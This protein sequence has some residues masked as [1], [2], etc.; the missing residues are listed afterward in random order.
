M[1][2]YSIAI[3]ADR[4]Y[5][6]GKIFSNSEYLS[7]FLY[8]PD[9]CIEELTIQ[10]EQD[11]SL[12]LFNDI[13]I[14]NPVSYNIKVNRFTDELSHIQQALSD[15][16]YIAHLNDNWD[17]EGAKKVP[18][19][20]FERAINFIN[21]YSRLLLKDYDTIIAAPEISPL[22]DGSIDLAWNNDKASLLVNIKNV[23]ENVAF[24]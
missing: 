2:D 10:G 5:F 11:N 12:D 24:Y 3:N 19:F 4:K 7:K 6:K 21:N 15:V 23:K 17:T 8:E 1:P 20:I 18:K 16:E 22:K 14:R 13:A 9:P